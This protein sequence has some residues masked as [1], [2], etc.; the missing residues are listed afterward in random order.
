MIFPLHRI[1]AH[2][3]FDQG[4]TFFKL[5]L[6][7]GSAQVI[8]Q[9]IGLLTGII[10]IRLLPPQE[11]AFYTLANAMLG[12]MSLLA[13]G[14]IST[15]VMSQGGKVWEDKQKLGVVLHT[16]MKLRTRFSV[17]T[18]AIVLPVLAYLLLHQNASLLTTL[19]IIVSI[20]PAFYASL[21]DALLEIV[22]KLHQ[23]IK[24][25]QQNSMIVNFFRLFLSGATLFFFPWA[26]IAI[27]AAGIPRII[28]NIK[29]KAIACKFMTQTTQADTMVQAEIMSVVKRS[30]PG[31]IYYCLSGQITIWIIS[32]FGNS[33]SLAASGALSRLG[34]LLNILTIMM[35]TLVIPR[36]ARLFSDRKLLMTRFV[37]IFACTVVM[38]VLIQG[39]VH[40]FSGAL[41][42]VLGPRYLHLT[43]ELFVYFLGCN[44]TLLIS[45]SFGLYASRGWIIKPVF[46]IS[47]NILFLIIGVSL[48][49]VSTLMGVLWFTLFINISQ[50]LMH[51]PFAIYKIYK[52]GKHSIGSSESSV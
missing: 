42:W 40:V 9:L 10:I 18:L 29:L 16:G 7:T 36:F 6:I 20:I 23:D 26:Y 34:M 35:G 33:S 19:L 48:F 1:R 11:Y 5:T 51:L 15:G 31:I 21:S 41:L 45:T 13:D 22:P 37:Q 39:L 43:E 30:L 38:C 28:G 25:L 44:V 47:Y 46:S 27:L 8:V 24:P 52:T 2:P 3:K 49:D 32:V 4:L 12:T 17:I 50:L 14:G